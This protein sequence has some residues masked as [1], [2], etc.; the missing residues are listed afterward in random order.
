[1]L[2]TSIFY[3]FAA[4][5]VFAS[6]RVVSSRN[7][8]H[9][10]IFLVLAFVAASPLWIMAGSEF[11]GLVLVFVYVGA[12]MTLFLFVVRML[13]LEVLPRS[14]AFVSYLPFA[15]LI[16]AII[17]ALIIDVIKPEHFTLI[18]HN[19]VATDAQYS[20]T[21]ALG[22]ALYTQY[23]LPFLLAGAI[24]LVA[25]V[26]SISLAFRGPRA[27]K[28]QEPS[29][30]IHINRQDRIRLVTNPVECNRDNP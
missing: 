9:S 26:A 14:R 24:L 7:P 11:L 8:V 2:H 20:N 22:M 12:V 15:M 5:L 19:V 30:Q 23:L 6:V 1:M 13:N 27:R 3:V 21:K 25:I 10:A 29:K 28:G 17:V 18:Q 16:V 4:L